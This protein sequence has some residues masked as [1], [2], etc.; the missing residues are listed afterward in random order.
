MI[1]YNQRFFQPANHTHSIMELITADKLTPYDATQYSQD[2]IDKMQRVIPLILANKLTPYDA[3]Q[4]SKDGIDKMQRVTPLIL[5]GKLSPYD[6][7]QYSKDGID[8][9]AGP[10]IGY[11]CGNDNHQYGYTTQEQTTSSQY[12]SQHRN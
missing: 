10:S 1:M 11:E 8:K 4:Y 6:A 9:L 3:T 12:T 7:T 5:A 2:G